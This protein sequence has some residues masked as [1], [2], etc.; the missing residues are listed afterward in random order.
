MKR[1][2]SFTG[3]HGTGKTT[4]TF[5]L[6]KTLKLSNT[7]SS[8]GLL[9]ENAALCPLPINRETTI[10]SQLWI[11]SSQII[12]EIELGSKY[13]ILICDR[14]IID[15]IAYS[16]YKGYNELADA[17]FKVALNYIESYTNIYFKLILNN[18]YL[19]SD[20]IR[21][22]DLKFQK[23]IENIMLDVYERIPKEGKNLNIEYI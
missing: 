4:S 6:A 10:D 11:F 15:P 2:Y 21:D 5:E 18:N 9:N 13:D 7:T 16:I 14:S 1:K 8:V 3:A 19:F 17:L 22:I 12:K 23:D 20:G